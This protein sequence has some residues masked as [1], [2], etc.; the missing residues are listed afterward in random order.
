EFFDFRV[1]LA[2]LP[3]L[4]DLKPSQTRSVSAI[5]WPNPKQVFGADPFATGLTPDYA[6]RFTG[7]LNITRPGLHTFW[8]GAYEGARLIMNGE[9]LIDMTAGN[10][11][12]RESSGA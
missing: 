12:L 5:N 7:F 11:S 6:A 9:R 10:G 2:A 4:R 1:P 8:L 3:E